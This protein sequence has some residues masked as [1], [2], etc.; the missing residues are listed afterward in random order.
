MPFDKGN[1]K[2]TRTLSGYDQPWPKTLAWLELA[3]KKWI[4]VNREYAEYADGGDALYWYNE[5]AAIGS[6]AAGAT[7]AGLL[8]L[9]EYVSVKTRE[10][11]T[12]KGSGRTDLYLTDKKHQATLEAKLCWMSPGSDQKTLSGIMRAACED[13][14][15]NQEE[16]QKIGVVFYVVKTNKTHVAESILLK[17]VE[18]VRDTNPRAIAWCFPAETRTLESEREE[19]KDYVWPGVVMAMNVA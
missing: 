8:C 16:V 13:A 6:L 3:V 11:E 17:A 18:R 7:R 4:A 2:L 19:R 5:R 9:E 1:S 12:K 15:C 14:R 10:T